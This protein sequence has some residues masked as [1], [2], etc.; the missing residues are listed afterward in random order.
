M[1]TKS[2][3]VAH[4]VS[5]APVKLV[6]KPLGI[7]LCGIIFWNPVVLFSLLVVIAS[8]DFIALHCTAAGQPDGRGEL[9]DSRLSDASLPKCFMDLSERDKAFRFDSLQL[10][11]RYV[12]QA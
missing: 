5:P 9:V 10:V 11:E 12:I 2:E 8:L 7:N 6:S 1:H 3:N 4:S